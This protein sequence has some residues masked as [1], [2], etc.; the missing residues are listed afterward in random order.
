MMAKVRWS[1]NQIV[2]IEKIAELEKEWKVKF[3]TEYINSVKEHDSGGL[4]V[5]EEDS[6]WKDALIPI[7]TYG[8]SS[9]YLLS[10][11]NIAYHDVNDIKLA[12]E[13]N[14]ELIPNGVYPFAESGGGDI[15]FFDY[16]EGKSEPSILFMNHERARTKGDLT[17]NELKEKPLEEWLKD[18]LTYVCNSFKDLLE[19]AYPAD[20]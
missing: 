7:P 19:I 13:S 17:E 14:L 1:W 5:L 12:Y 8:C 3:P 9:L 20:Y 10:F 16:R 4:E 2:E 18:N 6:H 11:I 15:F